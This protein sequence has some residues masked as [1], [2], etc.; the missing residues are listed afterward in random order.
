L[1]DRPGRPGAAE[2][3]AQAW[4]G[5]AGLYVLFDTNHGRIVCRLFPGQAPKTVENLVGLAEGIKEW[6]HPVSRETM[7]GERFYDGLVF[8]RVIPRLM[9]QGWDPLGG[10]V[11][12]PG[13]Q[14][15]DEIDPSLEF[16]GP[17]RLAMAN[18]GPLPT[19]A[20]SSSPR[21]PRRISTVAT[22][23]SARSSPERMW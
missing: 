1:D 23:S 20:S 16:D 19:A 2:N 8:H 3:G 9:I 17:G 7:K 13:Y 6:V 21:S 5:K 15:E 22:R 4:R 14:F 11:G 18:S 12:G 10:R